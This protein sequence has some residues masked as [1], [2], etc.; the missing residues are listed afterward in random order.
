MCTGP[1]PENSG[2]Q[3]SIEHDGT[4]CVGCD[5][6][7]DSITVAYAPDAGEVELPGKTG[8]TQANIDRLCKYLRPKA[9]RIRIVYEAGPCGYGLYRQLVHKRFDCMVCA[10]SL[11]PKRRGERVK[12]DRRDPVSGVSPLLCFIC[13]ICGGKDSKCCPAPERS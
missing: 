8:T 2:T 10:P 13:F 5:T 1:H 7:K 6:H 9:R 4:L 3:A 11:I 12:T